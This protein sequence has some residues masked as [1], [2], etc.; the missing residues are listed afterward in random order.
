M[1]TGVAV[2]VTGGGETVGL[3]CSGVIV[4][5]TVG[6]TRCGL[7]VG[8]G[9]TVGVTLIGVAVGEGSFFAMSVTVGKNL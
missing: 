2:G 3:I 1:G 6:V 7:K 5:V 4:G 9:V 8:P